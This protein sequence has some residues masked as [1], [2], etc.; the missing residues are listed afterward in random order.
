MAR[1]HGEL[2]QG[3]TE[4][5]ALV[6][7]V[8][9]ALVLAVGLTSG[10]VGGHVLAGL[11][12]GLCQLAPVP[13]PRPQAQPADLAACTL[14]RAAS[15]E[16]LAATIASVRAGRRG[17]LS[18]ARRSDGRVTVMLAQGGN[19]AADTGLGAWVRIGARSLGGGLR[20]RAGVEWTSGRSWTLPDE[21]AARR[22][23]E[24]YGRKA[25]IGGQVL[26]RVRSRCSLLCDAIGWRPHRQLPP[27]DATFAEGGPTLSFTKALEVGE[28]AGHVS[29]LLGR[30][31]HRDG[32]RTWYM[33]LEGDARLRLERALT[34]LDGEL[35]GDVV[36]AY[37]IDPDGNPRA[38]H[39]SLAGQLRGRAALA[40]ALGPAKAG[41]EL[42]AGVLA[43]LEASLDL[44][45]PANR[46]AAAGLLDA[47]TDP[48]RLLL[49]PARALELGERFARHGQLDRRLYAP[50]HGQWGLGAGV[51]RGVKFEAG[52]NRTTSGLRLLAAETRLPGLPFLPRDDCRAA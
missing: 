40:R 29:G 18:I 45:D 51:A 34:Q 10:G 44:R 28:A 36:L 19:L 41:A 15:S 5:V 16:E 33:K 14:E 30:R 38:L 6:T 13:C 20:A 12:R 50:T 7:L 2:G 25:T 49:G 31:E 21:A 3:A 22:F 9:I 11:Q 35:G 8:A 46:A 17:T 37:E 4:Y 47:L 52:F 27:P 24:T 42:G 32:G 23:V 1:R 43:E 26:D 48:R 39:A